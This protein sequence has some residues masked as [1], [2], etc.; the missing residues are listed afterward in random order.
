MRRSQSGLHTR[1]FRGPRISW[2]AETIWVECSRY[3]WMEP[4]SS[5][6]LRPLACTSKCWPKLVY[7]RTLLRQICP[8]ERHL[9]RSNGLFQSGSQRLGT[10]SAA[11]GGCSE[12]WAST[13]VVYGRRLPGPLGSFLF[14]C[15][16]EPTPSQLSPIPAMK[17][18]GRHLTSP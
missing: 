3:I 17:Q 1:H 8:G 7:W 6:P 15:E 12:Q 16:I 14:A 13:N 2:R 4:P 11:P 10:P 9:C 5:L 18:C